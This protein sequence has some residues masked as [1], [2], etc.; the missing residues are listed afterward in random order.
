MTTRTRMRMM[1]ETEMATP[2]VHAADGR[3]V[4][5]RDKHSFAQVYTTTDTTCLRQATETTTIPPLVLDV[6]P[7]D[8]KDIVDDRAATTVLLFES[9]VISGASHTG[10]PIRVMR[11]SEEHRSQ[12]VPMAWD[13]GHCACTTPGLM[14]SETG[15][16]TPFLHTS[17]DG[18]PAAP[19]QNASCGVTRGAGWTCKLWAPTLYMIACGS[20]LREPI[21]LRCAT[22]LPL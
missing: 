9:T 5:I 6:K 20:S 11:S 18:G 7:D 1:C 19:R 12:K 14:M 16:S 8:D 10:T 17:A 15:L 13:T 2:F 22:A 4:P 21:F 3:P